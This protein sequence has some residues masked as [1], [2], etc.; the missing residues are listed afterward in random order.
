MRPS[1]ARFVT[2]CQQALAVGVVIAMLGPAADVISL[3]VVVR[4]GADSHEQRA[5]SGE[6]SLVAGE[7]VK[8]E[9]A[10]VPLAP[11]R[12][13]DAGDRRAARGTSEF[14]SQPR[15]VDGL[16]TIGV[17]WEG[18]ALEEDEISVM[19]RTRT[20]G[21]WSA[22]TEV[23]YHDEHQPDPDTAEGRAS[24]P[25]TEPLIVGEVDEVQTRVVARRG[26]APVGLSMAVI[27]PGQGATVTEAPALDTE[28]LATEQQPVAEEPPA[29][30]PAAEA[31]VVEE[32]AAEQPAAEAP[33]VE[34]PAA[35][36]PATLESSEGEIALSAS[37]YTSK[38]R[39]YSR[40]QWGA[41]ESLRDRSSLRYFEVHAGFVHHTVNANNYTSDQV[42]GIIRS[43]YAYH[44]QSRGW[45]DIGYNF[46]VDRFGRLW[47]G[48]YGG[49]DRP[50][51]GAHTLGYN[52][53]AFAASAIGNFEEVR[54]TSAMVEA[55]GRLMG[56]KL[57]LHG[58]DA[59]STNQRVGDRT[60]PAING[61][62]D[63]GSTA[64]PG[65]YLYDRLGSMRVIAADVQ[66]DWSGRDRQTSI[67]RDAFPDLVMRRK[68]DG[69]AVIL[70]TGGMM[71][72]RARTLYADW[73]PYMNVVPTPDLTG[74][75]NADVLV[76]MRRGRAAV[77]P[78][79]GTGAFGDR[80]AY[81]NAFKGFGQITAAGDLDGDGRNDVV[82]QHRNTRSLYLYSGN[83]RGGFTRSLLAETWPYQLTAATGDITGDGRADVLGRDAGG[84][85]WVHPGTGSRALGVRARVPGKWA[86]WEAI[87][88]HGDFTADGRPDLL[89]QSGTGSS[90]VYPGNGRGGFKHWIGP[91]TAAQ[92]IDQLSAVDLDGGGDADV[93]G[94]RGPSYVARDHAGRQNTY[95]A[96][97]TGS[98]L[99]D[100]NVVLNVGDFDRDGPSDVVVR[101][102]NGDL[103]LHRGLA[104]GGLATPVRIATGFQGVR[105]LAAVGDVTGDG[106]PDLMGQPG[107]NAMRIY[108]GRGT[109]LKPSY[110]AHSAV[111][112][113]RQLGLGRW[114][115][116]G[117]PDSG[118]LANGQLTWMKGNGPG[119]LT[120]SRYSV[121]PDLSRYDWVLGV[122]DVDG[123]N[124][125]DLV[126]R[127]KGLLWLLPATRKGGF[128]QRRFITQG[129]GGY[130]L[131]G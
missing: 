9:V 29:E 105:L 6:A 50:V 10:E 1:K 4:P 119:G 101:L 36:D 82:A 88:G 38:P 99:G 120:G 123:R 115:A 110:V 57:A 81:T 45:S 85:L 19:A 117:A 72:F 48:R 114:N 61:H 63:A 5:A 15:R 92:G 131:A 127:E 122:G 3:D 87:T 66:A 24:R 91:F 104:T 2:L 126:V 32:P 55:Y 70:P 121:G 106:F 40:A 97:V 14:V 86:P 44:T 116:D 95:P 75:G 83:G 16:T 41:D 49:V 93:L 64:C 113:Q 46:L 35:E 74:D 69:R 52:D 103:M 51:V 108:P 107:T 71:G 111:S 13:D 109:G 31:P 43:I 8:P 42:P 53:Y 84:V 89:V 23:E 124:G 80:I 128:G 39:I 28:E 25:G 62:R 78:G 12:P 68:R 17:T 96:A 20:G 76:R 21:A 125:P 11:G 22:W 34:E 60:F 77:R 59:A 73:S 58:V 65:R 37:S 112:A 79:T 56:W 118:F 102:T 98:R 129:V 90:Y 130:D 7:P 30:E 67:V 33:V 54:P 27:G 26:A 94:F 47:E 18:E 100:A